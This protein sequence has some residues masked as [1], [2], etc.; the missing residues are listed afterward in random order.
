MVDGFV[1][2]PHTSFLLCVWLPT[3]W[4]SFLDLDLVCCMSP[5]GGRICVM[6]KFPASLAASLGGMWPGLPQWHATDPDFGSVASFALTKGQRKSHFVSDY[7]I[8]LIR[9]VVAVEGP[10]CLKWPSSWAWF[11]SPG[12]GNFFLI[13]GLIINISVSRGHT[14]WL[15]LLSSAFAVWK[16]VERVCGFGC[17]LPIPNLACPVILGAELPNAFDKF[18]FLDWVV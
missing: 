3:V 6:F 5:G 13:K 16:R 10:H 2:T 12:V 18:F 14:S 8:L 4:D 15:E 11:L 7:N 17:S 9:T 1:H